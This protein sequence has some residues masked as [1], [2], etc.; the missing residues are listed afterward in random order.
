MKTRAGYQ[1]RVHSPVE[2]GAEKIPAAPEQVS[3]VSFAGGERHW[4]RQRRPEALKHSEEVE[5]SAFPPLKGWKRT[6]VDQMGEEHHSLVTAFGRPSSGPRAVSVA[7]VAQEGSRQ[8][9]AGPVRRE[10]AV[11]P[12]VIQ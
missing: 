11:V 6:L 4:P 1:A 7:R 12:R 8:A 10:E 5:P 3:Q 2:P 9:M